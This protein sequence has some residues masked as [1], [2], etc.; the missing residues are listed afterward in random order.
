MHCTG[1]A[2]DGANTIFRRGKVL[3]LQKS[4]LALKSLASDTIRLYSNTMPNNRIRHYQ[5][6]G[7]M[8]MHLSVGKIV[9]RLYIICCVQT[10]Q[11]NRFLTYLSLRSTIMSS[12][13][14]LCHAYSW[15]IPGYPHIGRHNGC[16]FLLCWHYIRVLQK[17]VYK[18]ARFVIAF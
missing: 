2:V 9:A 7:L 11:C 1:S 14:K 3:S 18:H 12:Q 17:L 8:F 6:F 13:C 4:T 16:I 10:H 5:L 15:S